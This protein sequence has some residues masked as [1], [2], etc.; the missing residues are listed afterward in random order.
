M[1]WIMMMR[2]SRGGLLEV[3]V[4][5]GAIG[6]YVGRAEW[7]GVFVVQKEHYLHALS[8]LFS[9]VYHP[10][11]SAN[12]VVAYIQYSEFSIDLDLSIRYRPSNRRNTYIYQTS[13]QY[14]II[15]NPWFRVNTR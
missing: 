12:P 15:V 7:F 5:V 4:V 14:A 2:R 1:R 11:L 6:V 13:T 8:F 9:Y 3:L 10:L